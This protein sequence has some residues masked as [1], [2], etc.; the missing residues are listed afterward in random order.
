MQRLTITQR[1][2]VVALLPLLASMAASLA[3][4][5]WLRAPDGA[6]ALAAM[7]AFHAVM[8]VLAVAI[9]YAVARTLMRPLRDAVEAIDAIVCAELDAV[10]EAD[11]RHHSEIGRLLDG[12][13]RLADVL[14][15]RH[16]RDLVLIDVDRNR[17]TGRR[18]TLINMASELEQATEAG[19]RSIVEASLA[20]RAKANEMR[21]ALEMVRS[22]S[23]QTAIAAQGSRANNV[24]A[25]QYFEQITTAIGEIAEQVEHGSSVGRDAVTRA[26]HSRDSI[27]ALATAADDIGEIVGVINAIAE[28]TNLLALN[29][30]IEAARAGDAGRGFAVVAAE[31][32]S[33][34]TE[35]GKSTGQIGA[36]ITEIQSRTRQVV[37]S[38]AAVA[39]AI[40]QLSS[41]TSSISAAMEQQRAAIEGFSVSAHLTNSTI[42]DVADRM[43]EIAG[44]VVRS[45]ASA[46]DVADVAVDMQRTSET[47]R[48]ELPEIAR[49]ATRAD[50]REYP[51]YDVDIRALVEAN[52]RTTEMHIHDVSEAGVRIER[53]AGLTVGTRLVLTIRGLHPVSGRV[54]RDAGDSFGVCFE[55]QKLKTEEVRRLIAVAAA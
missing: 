38:L 18:T 55:P 27:N 12:I 28:Q 23:D 52:G 5:P 46:I 44:M 51:R 43:A 4:G 48:T 7:L 26:T 31:V 41:V 3:A 42:S 54:V 14:R 37:A 25:T 32:K 8:L 53:M 9:A 45:T 36:K 50:L 6:P 16:R 47:L 40:D 24:Q 33:L 20:L 49:R 19:M 15:E 22:A 17:Q 1:L 2:I 13:D 35:T 11:D 21:T 29:A 34:A 39:D 10:P 30:T